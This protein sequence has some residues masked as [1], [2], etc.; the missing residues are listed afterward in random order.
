MLVILTYNRSS[1]AFNDYLTYLNL[2]SLGGLSVSI[3]LTAIA[4][5]RNTLH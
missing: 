5:V 1:I 4:N 2:R 3:Q